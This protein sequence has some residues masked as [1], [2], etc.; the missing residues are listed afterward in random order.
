MVF[1]SSQ[2]EALWKTLL[3]NHE[4]KEVFVEVYEGKIKRSEQQN[5]YYWMYLSLIAD[6]TGYT[7]EEIHEWAKGKF[8][9]KQIK[10]LFGDKVRTKLSTTRLT[11]GEF[12]EYIM[13]IENETSVL[14]PPVQ[15]YV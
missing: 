5:N 14:A 13:K 12:A 10:E 6:E 3:K 8:L 15:D 1:K 2:H 7:S 9:T 11:K 4:D